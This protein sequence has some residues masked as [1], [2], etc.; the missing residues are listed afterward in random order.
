M[1]FLLL[2]VSFQDSKKI[3]KNFYE[4]YPRTFYCP[5]DIKEN[6]A[7]CV[8]NTSSI[9]WEHIVPAS[10]LS[11]QKSS[12]HPI[13]LKKKIRGRK[14]LEKVDKEFQIFTADM[15]N[16]I[17]ESGFLN[18]KRSNLPFKDSVSFFLRKEQPIQYCDFFV[19]KDRVVL[20]KSSIRGFVARAFLYMQ[21]TYPYNILTKEDLVLFHQWDEQYPSFEEECLR[22]DFIQKKQ[23]NDN[24]FIRRHCKKEKRV[25]ASIHEDKPMFSHERK[26]TIFSPWVKMIKKFLLSVGGR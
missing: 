25:F 13:C 6:K 4:K 3:L 12:H 18:R 21:N 15:H 22:N 8:G 20:P 24:P 1:L 11:K 10:F 7:I 14:C 17:P 16:L 9:E 19:Q 5:C 23:G 26:S 2:S